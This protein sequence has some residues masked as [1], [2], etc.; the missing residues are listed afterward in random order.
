MCK[1]ARPSRLITYDVRDPQRIRLSYARIC[2]MSL[3]MMTGQ[4]YLKNE[5]SLISLFARKA[6][7]SPRQAQYSRMFPNLRTKD[8]R[9]ISRYIVYNP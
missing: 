4:I 3:G 5:R 6:M 8:M 2:C 9:R 1:N 7:P